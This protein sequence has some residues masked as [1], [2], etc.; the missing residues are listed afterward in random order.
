LVADVLAKVDPQ[1]DDSVVE[2]AQR[3][4]KN[5]LDQEKT[6]LLTQL[7]IFCGNQNLDR[8]LKRLLELTEDTGQKVILSDLSFELAIEDLIS[9]PGSQNLLQ[10]QRSNIQ[11][12]LTKLN[13]IWR[14]GENRS[15]YTLCPF[16]A[17]LI[18]SID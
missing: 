16:T 17:E 12:W 8:A 3:M 7:G 15:E 18:K 9:H 1:N 2:T 10:E 11:D 14:E 13:L 5:L 4:R 6:K